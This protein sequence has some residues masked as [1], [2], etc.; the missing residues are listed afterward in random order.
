MVTGVSLT[1]APL[2]MTGKVGVWHVM[3]QN[4][5]VRLLVTANQWYL[6]DRSGN[7]LYK[8]MDK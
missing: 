2:N 7:G 3:T 1:L 6:G 8:Y 5:Q 4:W